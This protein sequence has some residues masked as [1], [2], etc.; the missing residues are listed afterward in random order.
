MARY[1]L[2]DTPA[3]TVFDNMTLLAAAT[4][5]TPVA[6]ISLVGSD[7]VFFK[8][9]VGVG[10]VRCAE[11]G[12]SLCALAILS[13]GVMVFEDTLAAPQ[14]ADSVPVKQGVRFYAGAPLE[15]P[16]GYLIG[17]ICIA[18]FKPRTFSANDRKILETLSRVVMEQMELRLAAMNEV[19]AQKQLAEEKD[20]F[21]SVASHELKTPLTSLTASLQLL[22]RLQPDKTTPFGKMLAQANRSLQKLNRLVTDLLN[23]RRIATG[24]LPLNRSRFRI[25]QLIEDCCAHI[26]LEGRYQ[27]QLEGKKELE[28]FADEQK[29]EQVIVNLVNNAIKYAPTSYHIYISLSCQDHRARVSVRDEG[30]GIPADKLPHIFERYYRSENQRTSGLGLGLYIISEIIRQHGG[31]LGVESEIGKGSSFWFTLPLN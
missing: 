8:S 22:D 2:F 1:R 26:H 14:V 4:F 15:S 30:P 11:R 25:G 16:D 6:L 24:N 23:V 31:E 13:P 10:K 9:T 28:V 27:I 3:E 20:A 29:I 17:T 7:T 21:L 5:Q 18:D 12:E 19:E